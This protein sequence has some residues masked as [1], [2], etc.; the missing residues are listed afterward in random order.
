M[1]ID[2]SASAEAITFVAGAYYR[3]TGRW[4]DPTQLPE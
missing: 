2:R 1:L 4:P 3:R